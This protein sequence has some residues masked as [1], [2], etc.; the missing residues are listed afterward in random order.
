M[1]PAKLLRPA[2]FREGD[3][4]PTDQQTKASDLA[5]KRAQDL[6]FLAPLLHRRRPGFNA[7]LSGPCLHP[8]NRADMS[9]AQVVLLPFRID[10]D[11]G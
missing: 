8:R 7:T 2:G 4:S 9:A 10:E 1:G 6:C 3:P 5:V 11:I